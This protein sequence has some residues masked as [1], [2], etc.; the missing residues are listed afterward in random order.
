MVP[1]DGTAQV[2]KTNRG[3]PMGDNSIGIHPG[4][5]NAAGGQNTV[6]SLRP[7][8]RSRFKSEIAKLPL[9]FA[10]AVGLKCATV[11]PGDDPQS[12]YLSSLSQNKVKAT[13]V[14]MELMNFIGDYE[15]TAPNRE[16]MKKLSDYQLYN[17]Y[18]NFKEHD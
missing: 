9:R 2:T 16:D 11:A 15:A 5:V 14:L 7:R 17:L 6:K 4:A 12:R 18:R 10:H 1:A 13:E 8:A 3:E